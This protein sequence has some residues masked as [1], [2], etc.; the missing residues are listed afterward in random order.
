MDRGRDEYLLGMDPLEVARLGRQHEAWREPTARVLDAVGIRPGTT[1]VDLGCGPGFTTL[2]L[3]TRVGPEGRV[4]AVDASERAL[5]ELGRRLERAGLRNV[6]PLRSEVLEA[7][8]SAVRP[9][10]V[11]TRWLLCYLAEPGRLV[12]RIAS[13]LPPGGRFAAIDYWNYRAIHAEPPTPRFE[14]VFR[15]VAES[16]AAAGGSLEVAGRLPALCERAGLEV[17]RVEQLSPVARPG[18]PLWLW[19]EEFLGLYLPKL[20]ERGTLDPGEAAAHGEEWSERAATP[21]ALL[22]LPPVLG[23]VARRP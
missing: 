15:K 22:F 10:V 14:R 9:D 6:E 3:A 21:G 13:W 2:E 11:F 8:L 19:V 7:D 17:E 4:V 16:F 18:E 12:A 5:A 20:V 1:V 23:I